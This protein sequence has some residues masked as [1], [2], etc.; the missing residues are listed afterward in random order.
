MSEN[1]T[2]RDRDL[3][4]QAS[5][6]SQARV[7][8]DGRDLEA[9][10]TI[11]RRRCRIAIK[12][13]VSRRNTGNVIIPIFLILFSLLTLLFSLTTFTVFTFRENT[14][15]ESIGLHNLTV[16]FT[17]NSG[18]FFIVMVFFSIVSDLNRRGE[19]SNE[20]K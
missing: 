3:F 12:L 5:H 8:P 17:D 14:H 7:K 10:Y 9:R 4:G 6:G 1:F 16:F 20:E 18:A 19:D 13:L 11:A 15:K 2:N